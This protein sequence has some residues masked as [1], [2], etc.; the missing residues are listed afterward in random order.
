MGGRGEGREGGGVCNEIHNLQLFV[1][2]QNNFYSFSFYS[3][4]LPFSSSRPNNFMNDRVSL[5]FVY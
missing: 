2:M 1:Y 5:T 4:S 3:V